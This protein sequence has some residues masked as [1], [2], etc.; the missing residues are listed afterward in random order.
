MIDKGT[1]L[2]YSI[3]VTK[4]NRNLW[5]YI[6]KY[7]KQQMIGMLIVGVIGGYPLL[8][9]YF[10]FPVL[11]CIVIVCF[12]EAA[13]VLSFYFEKCSVKKYDKLKNDVRNGEYAQSAEWREEYLE[14]VNKKGFEHIKHSSMKKDLVLRY[15]RP[16]GF[17]W[18]LFG[19]ALL[20][21][22]FIVVPEIDLML[23]LSFVSVALITYGIFRLYPKN[24]KAFFKKCGAEYSDINA[25]YVNGKQLTYK[26]TF[27]SISDVSYN[28]GINLGNSY[29]V[30]VNTKEIAAIKYSEILNVKHSIL[31]TK[32][33]GNGLY[34]GTVYT[35]HIAIT[36]HDK[37][38]NTN[39]T[40]STQLSEF[41][42]ELACE[43]LN[44][45]I[46]TLELE[47]NKLE[48]NV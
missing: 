20:I 18:I 35:H 36:V 24:V 5:R 37:Q 14:F 8:R 4:I 34:T 47:N 11:L 44:M 12:V 21:F 46:S 40:F 17:F 43:T 7:T 10:Q 15:L 42:A 32:F 1:A 38:R 25:S 22:N 6:M 23:F 30:I 2:L 16:F 33:Y 29:V 3:R 13:C 41:Q 45:Q 31:S 39:I 28:G 27:A 48:V 9:F 26:K 19:I